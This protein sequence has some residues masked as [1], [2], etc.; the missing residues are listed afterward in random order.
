MTSLRAPILLR[1]VVRTVSRPQWTQKTSILQPTP[2]IRLLSSARVVPSIRPS[3]R[4]YSTTPP[5]DF[6][7][8]TFKEIETLSK[9]PEDKYIID[10][11][12]PQELK[13]NGKIPNALNLPLSGLQETLKLSEQAFHDKFEFN[14]PEKTKE[15]IFYCKAGVRS[16]NASQIAKEAGYTKIGNYKGSFD[17]WLASKGTVAKAA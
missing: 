12:E 11:R 9:S 16:T 4:L 7:V 6:K 10:V 15:V 2:T 17:D 1:S 3:V 14:K 8:Y 13:D 5:E